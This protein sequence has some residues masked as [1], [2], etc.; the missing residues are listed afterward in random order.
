M[1]RK[2]FNDAVTSGLRVVNSVQFGMVMSRSCV[3]S[4]LEIDLDGYSKLQ[5]R[6]AIGS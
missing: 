3:C 4:V 6:M 1:V 5:C 2:G